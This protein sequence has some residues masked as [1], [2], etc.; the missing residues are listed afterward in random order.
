MLWWKNYWPKEVENCIEERRAGERNICIYKDMAFS[1]YLA[2]KKT[3]V[4]LPEKTAIADWRGR[5]YSYKYLLEMTD[6]TGSWLQEQAGVKK[7]CRL[8]ILLFN[9]IEFVV[10]YLA[11]SKIGAVAVPLPGKFQKPEILSL[12]EKSQAAAV[13]CEEKFK[14]WLQEIRGVKIIASKSEGDWGLE[15]LLAG[16]SCRDLGKE[17]RQACLEDD[18]ILMF[19]SGTTSKSKGVILKNY[20]VMNSVEA[21]IKTLNLSEK[22]SSLIATPMYHVTGMICILSVFLTVGGTVFIQPKVDG[23]AVL[24]CFLKEK[25]TFY[26]ASPTVFSILLEKRKEYPVIPWVRGFA[27]GSGNM[28]PENIKKLKEWMPKAQFHTVYGLT[29]TAGAGVIFPGGAADSPWIG[30]SG[31]P[32]PDLKVKIMEGSRE[33]EAEEIGEICLKG[34]FVLESYHKPWPDLISEDGWLRTGD[35][36]YYNQAG[37]LYI[38][39]RKKDMINRGGEKICSFDIENVLH[40]LPYVAEAAV[41][42]V[43][44]EKYMEVPAALI[45]LEKGKEALEEELK[46]QLK[47]RIAAFKIPKYIVFTDQIPKTHNGKIDKKKIREIMKQQIF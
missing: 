35:L 37:Y 24:R 22:D 27:C 46:E 9:G 33:L 16:S 42:A 45:R 36:G 23:D 34:S 44:D 17:E 19:T 12:V 47:T 14:P 38:V 20:H 30:S 8:G 28:A 25:I 32:M 1:M 21:Y 7:G 43:P 6:K 13:I 31:V 26:H 29:E 4:R 40:T 3:A 39:D 18:A 2:F 41:V 11:A 5:T 10:A 15:Y